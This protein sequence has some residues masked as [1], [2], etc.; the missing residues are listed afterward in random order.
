VQQVLSLHLPWWEKLV[1]MLQLVGQPTVR[2][3]VENLAEELARRLLAGPPWQQLVLLQQR[4]L[5]VQRQQWERPVPLERLAPQEPQEPQ[6]QQAWLVQVVLQWPQE[7]QPQQVRPVPLVQ[8]VPGLP[9][10]PAL[11]HRVRGQPPLEEPV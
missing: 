11:R 3:L 4:G 6:L 5:E 1:G 10:Q 7:Q 9:G 2:Q 8:P